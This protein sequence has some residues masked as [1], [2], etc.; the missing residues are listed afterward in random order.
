MFR[1]NNRFLFF[2]LL[3]VIISL[4]FIVQQS[5]SQSPDLGDVNEDNAIDIVD[6]LLTAQYY[7]GLPVS[8]FIPDAADV[9]AGGTI[10]IVDALLIAQFY[11]GLISQFPGQVTAGMEV[12]KSDIE[13][14]MNPQLEDGELDSVVNGNNN[15]GF[16]FFR[17]IKDD[18]ENLFFFRPSVYRMLLPCVMPV[19]MEIRQRKLPLSCISTSRRTGFIMPLIPWT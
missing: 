19:P 15:F 2:T 16:D 4:F 14:N 11:V 18:P 1:K 12:V 8:T 13:R 5:Y 10:N 6:A 3:F 7:V 9:D 17:V